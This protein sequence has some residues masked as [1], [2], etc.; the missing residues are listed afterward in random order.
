MTGSREVRRQAPR[1]NELAPL[2]QVAKRTGTREERQVARA[3]MHALLSL[4]LTV[5]AAF[6]GYTL[7]RP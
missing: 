2:L 3:A 4:T 6:L 1:W 5:A 7:A